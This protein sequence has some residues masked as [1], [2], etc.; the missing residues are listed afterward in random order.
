MDSGP[1]PTPYSD[2]DPRNQTG[3]GAVRGDANSSPP[4]GPSRSE[5]VGPFSEYRLVVDGYSVPFVEARE[6]DGG[7]VTFIMDNRLAWTVPA[8]AFAATAHLIATAYAL[9]IGL[10]CAPSDQYDLPPMDSVPAVMRPRRT[11]EIT[12]VAADGDDE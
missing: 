4:Q 10:P 6:D 8:A 2:S 5:I 3:G 7:T 11:M 12:S 1:R 9:G